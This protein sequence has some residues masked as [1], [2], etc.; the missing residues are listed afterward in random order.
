MYAHRGQKMAS[1]P[2]ELELL[3]VVG[4]QLWE[5]NPGSLEEYQILFPT[6]QSGP[7]TVIILKTCR[8]PTLSTPRGMR[9]KSQVTFRI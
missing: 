5:L 4:Y 8:F 1:Y 2:L 6:E 7:R 9:K 3:R